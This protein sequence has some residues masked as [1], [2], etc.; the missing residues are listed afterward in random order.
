MQCFHRPQA[1][2]PLEER[3]AMATLF[4]SHRQGVLHLMQA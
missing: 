4:E 3:P 1:A 2:L